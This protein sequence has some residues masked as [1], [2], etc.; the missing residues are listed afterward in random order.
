MHPQDLSFEEFK[1]QCVNDLMALQPEFM[2]L[3]EIDNYDEWFYDH[4]IGAF[5]FK[6]SDCK[7]LYFKYVDVGSFSTKTNTWDWSWDNKTTQKHVSRALERVISFGTENNFEHLTKG[8]IEGDEYTGWAMA[9]ISAKLLNIIGSY[10]IPTSILSFIS[11][12]PMN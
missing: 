4:G 2:K 11:S 7:N 10:R 6:S 3:Y 8:L 9:A 1:D 5:H 12:S